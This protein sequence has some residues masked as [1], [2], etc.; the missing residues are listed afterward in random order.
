MPLFVTLH[1]ILKT[2]SYNEKEVLKEIC[3]MANK[4]VVMSHKA[5]EFLTTIYDVPEEKIALLNMVFPI[6]ISAPK[7]RKKSLS[8]KTKK[9]C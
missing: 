8:L 3:K 7:N 4:V 9:Y 6:F 2:P 5:V 1:T